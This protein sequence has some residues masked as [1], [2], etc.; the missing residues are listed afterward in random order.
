MA[1]IVVERSFE[2]P[3]VFED[4]E[5]QEAAVAWCFEQHRVKP[6]RSFI[7]FDRRSAVCVYEA[8]DAEAVRATQDEVGLAY[9]QLWPAQLMEPP[10][11]ARPA[12]YTTVMALRELPVAHDLGAAMGLFEMSLDC[13]KRN[14]A[15]LWHSYLALDGMRMVCRYHAP[16]AEGVRRANLESELPTSAIW[17]AKVYGDAES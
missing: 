9:D 11:R 15:L 7:S 14:R 4:L 16:D 17:P 6:L 12:G 13:M 10:G 3:A 5:A 8:P 2:A 1:L